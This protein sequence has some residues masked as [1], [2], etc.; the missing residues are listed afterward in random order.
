MARQ[1]NFLRALT[2]DLWCIN[3]GQPDRDPLAQNR[4]EKPII[5]RDCTG[6][7]VV[8]IMDRYSDERR[9]TG[10]VKFGLMERMGTG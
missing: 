3:T 2:T 6:V 7:P 8:A 5:Q 4:R 1:A 9:L 10:Q